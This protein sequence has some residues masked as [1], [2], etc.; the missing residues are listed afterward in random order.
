MAV[1]SAAMAT[2]SYERLSAS[3]SLPDVKR[4]GSALEW[5]EWV[6][7]DDWQRQ[8]GLDLSSV[9]SETLGVSGGRAAL[10]AMSLS[11]QQLH[12]QSTAREFG[13]SALG[14]FRQRS[15]SSSQRVSN[16]RLSGRSGSPTLMRVGFRGRMQQRAT[17]VHSAP[18]LV[19]MNQGEWGAVMMQRSVP[20]M[21]QAT[22]RDNRRRASADG[23]T[24]G[25]VPLERRS[26]GASPVAQQQQRARR[27]EEL[28]QRR[29]QKQR[30]RQQQ[31]RQ[32]CK[33]QPQSAHPDSELETGS[34][35]D[36]FSPTSTR[37]NFRAENAPSSG[38]R[39]AAT[40]GANVSTSPPKANSTRNGS[41]SQ[42]A[43]DFDLGYARKMALKSECAMLVKEGDTLIKQYASCSCHEPLEASQSTT[44]CSL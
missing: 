38:L 11:Q 21:P 17:T 33:G 41:G 20:G 30:Q 14:L 25:L 29:L 44:A 22:W 18:K 8:T 32:P 40:T 4:A 9:A 34:G 6:N 12:K 15:G 27:Q 35:H 13:P 31:K 28:R 43:G 16:G 37:S 39:T 7:A 1:T 19:N 2:P 36:Q 5:Q 3:A 24:P 23:R 10:G 42:S 26:V